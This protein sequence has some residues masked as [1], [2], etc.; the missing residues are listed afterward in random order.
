MSRTGCRKLDVLGQEL[1]VNLF[2]LGKFRIE[3]FA[4]LGENSKRDTIL[5]K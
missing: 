3:G 4:N 2:S 1:G 5:L